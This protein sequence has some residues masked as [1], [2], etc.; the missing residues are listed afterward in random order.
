MKKIKAALGCRG[1]RR[2]HLLYGFS[3]TVGNVVTGFPKP[4]C[5]TDGHGNGPESSQHPQ[6]LL[7]FHSYLVIR[8]VI[9]QKQHRAGP[10]RRRFPEIH[11]CGTKPPIEQCHDCPPSRVKVGKLHSSDDLA[12][13]FG[14]RT[15]SSLGNYTEAAFCSN[16]Q[17]RQVQAG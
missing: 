15:N 16:E 6:A 1:R 14:K 11:Y 10:T 3:I 17:L 8:P 5:A 12:E 4:L 7:P 9:T 2:L 13:W